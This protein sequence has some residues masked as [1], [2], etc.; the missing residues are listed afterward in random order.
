[1][2]QPLIA[3]DSMGKSFGSRVVLR[4]ASLWAYAGSVTVLLGR[5]GSGK[6]TLIRV[7]LGLARAD[8]GT[9]RWDGELV[10]APSLHE[11]S[12]RG[13][14]FVPDKGLLSRR[15]R[16]RDQLDL[17]AEAFGTSVDE[18]VAVEGL[19]GRLDL[20][21]GQLSGGEERR[22]E[23]ALA[24]LREPLCLLADEPFAGLAPLDRA[25][26]AGDLREQTG[27]GAAVIVTGHEVE[28]LLAIADVVIWMVAGTTHVLGSAAAARRHDQFR[29]E[30]LGPSRGTA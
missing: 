8:R 3:F 25:R 9:V 7:G 5:N 1:M 13:L 4:S 14:F 23:M 2:T 24:R 15:M 28:E 26:V 29:R 30:Y 19:E 10:E 21:A 17:Y 16:L 18:A 22:A 11:L 12:R 27:R 20:R 6:S